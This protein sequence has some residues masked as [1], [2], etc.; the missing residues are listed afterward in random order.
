M[1][2]SAKTGFHKQALDRLV[3][4]YFLTEVTVK[5]DNCGVILFKKTFELSILWFTTDLQPLLT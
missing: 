5:G 1:D 2:T 4:R 3:E